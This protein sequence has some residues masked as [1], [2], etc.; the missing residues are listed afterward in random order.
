MKKSAFTEEE[1]AYITRQFGE[2]KGPNEMRRAFRKKFYPKN[3][4]KVPHAKAFARVMD[5]LKNQ[6]I[7]YE[8]WKNTPILHISPRPLAQAMV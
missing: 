1:L 3:P 2:G 8:S 6:G 5:R 4:A 7:W